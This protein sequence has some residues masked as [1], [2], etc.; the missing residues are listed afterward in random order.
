MIY[1]DF[2]S[3]RI[4]HVGA[5]LV[6]REAGVANAIVRGLM[7]GFCFA[8]GGLVLFVFVTN[9]AQGYLLPIEPRTWYKWLLW[10]VFMA[11]F[12]GMLVAMPI[13]LG[14]EVAQRDYFT[15]DPQSGTLAAWR[16]LFG[17]PIRQRSYPL[18]RFRQVAIR[19]ALSGVFGKHWHWIVWLEGETPIPLASVDNPVLARTVANEISQVTH[20]PIVEHP[21]DA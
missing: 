11:L 15:I 3:L 18:S 16:G 17:V 19:P 13:K 8:V 20:L 7:G 4:D 21:A 6:L 1:N 14:I 12:G 9:L 10:A 2:K 5:G